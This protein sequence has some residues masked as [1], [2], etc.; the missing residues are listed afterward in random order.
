MKASPGLP[1]QG[2]S[3]VSD[4]LDE[5]VSR[6]APAVRVWRNRPA[7]SLR[8]ESLRRFGVLVTSLVGASHNDRG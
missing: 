6:S 3:Q 7:A 1:Q 8:R 2:L 5:S 4:N